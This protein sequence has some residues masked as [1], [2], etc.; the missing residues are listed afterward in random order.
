MFSVSFKY[1]FDSKKVRNENSYDIV[2]TIDH[3]PVIVT[4][5]VLAKV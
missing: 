5:T 1:V 2:D 4:S 3:I